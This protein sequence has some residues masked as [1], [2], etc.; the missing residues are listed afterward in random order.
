MKNSISIIAITAILISSCS[1]N[2]DI[3]ETENL[4]AVS[5]QLHQTTS[6]KTIIYNSY[7]S[8]EGKTSLLHFSNTV[9]EI[10]FEG[11]QTLSG[12]LTNY[13]YQMLQNTSLNNTDKTVILAVISS[14]RNHYNTFESMEPVAANGD[15][16]NDERE[17]PDWELVI[18][19]IAHIIETALNTGTDN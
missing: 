10:Q 4:Y 16:D 1:K 18:T 14:V 17:D 9:L 6:L 13:E 8:A 11:H 2:F 15:D 19:D 5:L 3:S 7:L 12:F